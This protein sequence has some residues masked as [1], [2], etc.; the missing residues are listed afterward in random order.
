ML[1]P[2]SGAS[3][4]SYG[5][6]QSKMAALLAGEGRSVPSIMAQMNQMEH[7]LQAAEARMQVTGNIHVEPT[8]HPRFLRPC[9]PLDIPL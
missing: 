9:Y 5:H 6:V 2:D 1:T 4:E 8:T 7:K 3:P